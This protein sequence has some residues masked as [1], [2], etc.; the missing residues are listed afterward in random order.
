M[1]H[2][3][4][5]PGYH[6]LAV[7]VR[8]AET[9]AMGVAHHASYV[10]WLESGRVEWL[11]QQGIAYAELERQGLHLP[12]VELRIRYLRPAHFDD[13]LHVHTALAELT[14]ARVCFIYT[15]LR[16]GEGAPLA[17]AETRHCYLDESGRPLRLPVTSPH[18][19]R[20][21]GLPV[22]GAAEPQQAPPAPGRGR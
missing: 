14:R 5:P 7:R 1:L 20:F 16:P 12:V 21:A 9:D 11:R 18:W 22:A 13:L 4:A 10:P 8:Y 19:Q 6:V 15:L 3:V 17:A 2:S